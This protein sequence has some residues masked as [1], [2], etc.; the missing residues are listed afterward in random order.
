MNLRICFSKTPK[1]NMP[2]GIAACTSMTLRSEGSV[3]TA[4]ATSNRLAGMTSQRTAAI[5]SVSR[6]SAKRRNPCRASWR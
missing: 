4:P 6:G 1:V 5:P 3:M 2:A